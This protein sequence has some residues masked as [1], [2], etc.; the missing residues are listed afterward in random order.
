M[1]PVSKVKPQS[2]AKS[3]AQ[4]VDHWEAVMGVGSTRRISAVRWAWLA[5]SASPGRL[6]AALASVL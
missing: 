6:P 2:A 1:T 3:G 4:Q 5:R